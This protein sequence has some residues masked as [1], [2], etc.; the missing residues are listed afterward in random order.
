VL[1]GRGAKKRFSIYVPEQL[2]PEIRTALENGRRLKDLIIDAGV[3]YT[4]ALKDERKARLKKGET[5][6]GR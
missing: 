5:D 6:A 2:V 3:R 1:Y 4:H